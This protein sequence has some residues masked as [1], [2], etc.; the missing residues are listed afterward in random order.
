MVCKCLD[1]V[2]YICF[3]R[4]MSTVQKPNNVNNRYQDDNSHYQTQFKDFADTKKVNL[5]D[6]VA[7]MNQERKLEKK[8]N[9]ILSAAAI[10]AVT[11][12][13]IILTL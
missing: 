10:S 3:N 2:S 8:N 9:I 6:L 5:T 12:L 4:T 7:R 1:T 13:G 11:V